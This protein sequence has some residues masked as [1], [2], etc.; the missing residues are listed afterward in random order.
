MQQN[1]WMDA[2]ISASR[3]LTPT[4]RELE[5]E[6]PQAI[7]CA[8]GSHL[9]VEVHI[10]GRADHR[11]YSVV[12]CERNKIHIA[13]KAQ[14]S[15]RGGSAYMW[16]LQGGDG[17]RVTMPRCNFDLS[18]A[19]PFYL[20]L[21]G[22]VGV[23]PM[24]AM[25][26]HLA[27][28]G[29]RI[30]MIYAA[31]SREEFAYAQELKEALGECLELYAADEGQV[32]DLKAEIA[33]IPEDGELY[34]CGPLGLMDA[35]REAWNDAGR[36]AN[37]LRY[38]TFGSSG[39]FKAEA[40]TVHIP[41]LGAEVLVHEN[42]S[43]L[44]ALTEAGIDVLSECRRGECGLC[45]LDIL[46]VDGELDHRDVFFSAREHRA[47]RK[48]CACVSRVINGGITIDPAWRGDEALLHAA[49]PLTSR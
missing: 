17:L 11:S 29:E 36:P 43:M 34:M 46:A 45:A 23:T 5:I 41:R 4:I 7:S 8:P 13:V 30:R 35:V 38:E 26:R 6:L 2:V 37:K 18:E 21:A 42:Q 32:I 27:L 25:A 14:P 48:I 10:D 16:T 33:N 15:S 40:F 47:G 20:L 44:E 9:N 24:V 12:R 22:G 1:I 49:L 39:R 19:T 3:A 28:R 31:R